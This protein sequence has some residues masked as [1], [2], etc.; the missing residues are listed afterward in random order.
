MLGGEEERYKVNIRGLG[1]GKTKRKRK[2]RRML[3][4]RR[5]GYDVGGKRE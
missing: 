5:K 3:R 4:E 1:R 2:K